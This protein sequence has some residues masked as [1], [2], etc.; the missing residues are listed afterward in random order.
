MEAKNDTAVDAMQT[1][2]VESSK[3]ERDA[4]RRDPC[5]TH[6]GARGAVRH[7][8]LAKRWRA[9]CNETQEEGWGWEGINRPFAL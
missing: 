3:G 9:F 2:G 4:A 8:P 7:S 6:A 5:E 1:H